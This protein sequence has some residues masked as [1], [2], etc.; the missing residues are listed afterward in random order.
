M[1]YS[2]GLIKTDEYGKY[3]L[4]DKLNKK[5]RRF[6]KSNIFSNVKTPKQVILMGYTTVKTLCNPK[7][8]IP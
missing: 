6:L 1:P 4:S 7:R 3:C 8:I 5:A 2:Y